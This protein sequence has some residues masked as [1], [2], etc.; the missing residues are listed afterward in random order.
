ME[1]IKFPQSNFLIEKGKTRILVD[2]GFLTFE[3]FKTE[4]FGKL[5]AV[6]VSHRHFDHIDHEAAK[7]WQAKGVPIF[8]NL[9]VVQ[10]LGEEG[11]RVNEIKTNQEFRVGDLKIETADV[12]HCKLLFCKKCDKQLGANEILPVVKRCRLHPEEELEKVVGP[13]NT[14]FLIDNILFHSGDGIEIEGLTCQN[15]IVP[16]NGPTIDFDIAW[17]F[18]KS[19][20]AKRIIPMHYSHPTFLADPAEFAKMAKPGV[21]VKILKDGESLEI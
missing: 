12:P 5:D 10:V 11:I 13:P 8:G 14:G 6:L 7:I 17:E 18:A 2:P 9:D 21:E 19:L 3:K 16:I 4:D 20:E 15:A 1:I